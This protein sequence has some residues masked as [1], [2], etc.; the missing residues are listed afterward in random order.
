MD[1][2]TATEH[3]SSL[4]YEIDIL[5]EAMKSLQWKVA[6]ALSV[7]IFDVRQEKQKANDRRFHRLSWMCCSF[8]KEQQ[9]KKRS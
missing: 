2:A 7:N 8:H 4:R 1:F 3:V 9:F 6:Q 5:Q